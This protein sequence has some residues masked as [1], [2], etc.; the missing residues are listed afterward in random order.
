MKADMFRLMKEGRDIGNLKTYLKMDFSKNKKIELNPKN[1]CGVELTYTGPV[2][3]KEPIVDIWNGHSM[4]VRSSTIS[5]M[6]FSI[7]DEKGKNEIVTR[8]RFPP[9]VFDYEE[10]LNMSKSIEFCLKNI[11]GNCTIREAIEKTMN[12]ISY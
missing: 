9:N 10:A 4:N 2:Q 7:V 8:L 11:P 6:G 5:L 1:G 3:F 12:N